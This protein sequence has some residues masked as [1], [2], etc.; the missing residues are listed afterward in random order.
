MIFLDVETT[1]SNKGNPYDVNNSLVVI[2]YR[3][4]KK[5]YIQYGPYSE[6]Y[7]KHLQ[8][9]VDEELLVGFN[10]KFDLHW[11]SNVG[12]NLDRVR[13]WDCSIAEFLF[14]YQ[15]KRYPS[16]DDTLEKYGFPLKLDQVSNEYWSK[17]INTDQ[18]PREILTSYLEGDLEKTEQV[19]HKQWEQFQNEFKG[20]FSLFKLQCA[21]LLTLQD[22]ERNGV[23]FNS[24]RALKH[25]DDLQK[26]QD[27]LQECIYS[28]IGD[29]PLSLTSDRD[30]S[31]LLYGG[32]HL[33]ELRVPVGTYKSGNRIGEVRYKVVHQTYEFPQLITPLP[34]TQVKE[35]VS[36]SELELVEKGILKEPR[37]QYQV[38]EETL[39]MVKAKGKGKEIIEA[40]LEFNKLE[41]LKTT[42][43]IGWT[44]INK[45]MNW[46]HNMLHSNFAQV[47]TATGRLSCT[48]P[49]QQNPDKITKTFC[50]SRYE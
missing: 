44:E 42:Y 46:K 43:L 47:T 41:K 29:V 11:L 5:N 15:T 17:G 4:K 16:L 32:V 35:K 34:N 50:E 20:M 37:K 14:S 23:Y 22:M 7:L 10:I 36:K 2:G 48:S 30:V 27:I 8:R 45:K 3:E 21:D 19:F 38:N 39:R 6:S 31:T 13:V 49:N 9:K 25:A 40:L 33:Q 26:R 1:I 24:E 28:T 12:I 18:I